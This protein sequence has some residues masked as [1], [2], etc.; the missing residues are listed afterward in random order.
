[1]KSIKKNISIFRFVKYISF[2]TILSFMTGCSQSAT[3]VF[4]KDPIYAQNI[5][6]TKIGKIILNDEVSSLVNVTYLNSVDSSKWDNGKQ[7]FLV[8]SYISDEKSDEVYNL[9]LNDKGYEKIVDISKEDDIYKNIA[10]RNNWGQYSIMT[11]ADTENKT[12]TLL[13]SDTKGNS[14]NVSFSK[15]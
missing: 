3:S 6:Y 10:F 7:N 13:Y 14:T 5:Q 12:I 15:E 8:G 2:L 1:M 11:F 9:T 4:K